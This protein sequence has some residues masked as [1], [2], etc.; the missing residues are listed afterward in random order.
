VR[1]LHARDVTVRFGAF[2]ALDG[3]DLD[4]DAG[5]ATMLVG[6]NGAGKSTLIKVL[7]GLVRPDAGRFEA[8]GAP[9]SIDRAWKERIGY[10]PEAVAFSEN[11]SGRQV[12][13]FFARARGVPAARVDAVL[14]RVGL[15]EAGRRPTRGYSRGMR[16]RLG[17]GVAILATPE[18]LVLDEPT[19]GLDQQGLGVLWSVMEEWRASGRMVLVSTHDLALMERRVDEI[20][21]LRSGRLLAHGS[22][23]ELRRSA[24]IP[25]RI[26]LEV[27]GAPEARVDLLC[28]AMRKWGKGRVERSDERVVVE[29]PSDDVL[30]VVEIQAGFSGVVTGLRVEEPT[31]DV[32]Y[33][34]LV[35]SA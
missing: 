26:G 22:A 6:P 2:T 30:E 4:L 29:V 18:L 15:V 35:G 21:V 34:K 24:N 14:E 31:L 13:R 23:D 7:L 5:K 3:V 17:L 33:D 19:S 1:A 9:M 28:E 10:L 27:G 25:H 12:L 8:D 20:C 16:Q 11:L 32:V